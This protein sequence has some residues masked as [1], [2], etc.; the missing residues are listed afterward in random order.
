MQRIGIIGL[1]LIGGSL[2]E[3][4]HQR[5]PTLELVGIDTHPETLSEA[6]DANVFAVVSDKLA[7]TAG[8]D[9][10][11]VCVPL[12]A[13]RS[14]FEGIA[15]TAE[16]NT[17]VIDVIGLKEPVI[18]L[19]Q[20]T[21]PEHIFVGCHP[22]AGGTVAGFSE[23]RAELFDGF[24][25]AICPHPDSTITERVTEFWGSVGA[26]ALSMTASEHDRIVAITSHLPYLTS[27]ILRSRAARDETTSGLRGK[28]FARATRY[29]DFLP[30]I[31][32]SVV[33]HNP[34][35]PALLREFSDLYSDLADE[36]EQD[37]SA[38]LTLAR[39][40]DED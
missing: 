22:M 33:G 18:K 17:W 28:G 12:P 30:E 32:A 9:L 13:L 3:A 2:A 4:L 5:T 37:P 14:V 6:R 21:L 31:M 36:L 20:E 8:C 15:K 38:L 1:G 25:V 27:V 19:A 16:P 35:T 11:V 10:I 40:I 7:D 26:E 24:P 39:S 34:H 29:A 23:R